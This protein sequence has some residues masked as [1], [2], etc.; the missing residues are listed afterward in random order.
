MQKALIKFAWVIPR[1]HDVQIW[2]LQKAISFIIAET[3]F[4]FQNAISAL[5]IEKNKIDP[6][7]EY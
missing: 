7:F 1:S 3:F 6:H 2:K 4:F 5:L